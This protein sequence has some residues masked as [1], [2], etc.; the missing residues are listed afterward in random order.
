MLDTVHRRDKHVE[1]LIEHFNA[2]M[3]AANNDVN[4]LRASLTPA[5]KQLISDELARVSGPDPESM[6]YFLENYFVINTKGGQFD[7]EMAEQELRTMSPFMDP[8]EVLWEEVVY[9]WGHKLPMWWIMLKARQIGW[10]T[11]VQGMLFQRVIF[12]KNMSVLVIADE[13]TRT[14]NIFDKSLLAYNNLPFFM[15]PEIQLN[16]R[17]KGILRFDRN[18]QD[19]RLVNP[20]LN[21]TFFTD[22]AN[23][24][25]GSSRGFTLHGL[26]A[27]EFGLFLRPKILTQDIVP[28]LAKKNPLTIAVV[29]GT[30]DEGHN[31]TYKA[32]WEMAMKG[33]GLF[34]PMFAA[35]WK[36]KT[37]CK[38]FSSLTEEHG[39]LETQKTQHPEELELM[40]KVEDEFGYRIR[41]DQMNWY[42][43]QADQFEGTEADREM[44]EQEYPSYPKSAFRTGGICAFPRK[45]LT[46]IEVRDVR[47]PIWWGELLFRMEGDQ[48]KPYFIKHG[49]AKRDHNGD[50]MPGQQ[51]LP[52]YGAPLWI[53]E[54]PVSKDIYYEASD[55]SQGIPDAHERTDFAAAQIFRVPRKAGERIRQCLEFKGY[56]DPKTLAKIVCQLGKFYN[57]CEMAPE[58]NTLTEHIGNIIHI[59]KYPNIYRWRRQDKITGHWTNFF[60]WETQSKSRED[61]MARFKALLIEDSIEIRSQRLLDEAMNFVDDGS[62]R[63]EAVGG[64]HDDTLFAAMICV[65]CLMELDPRLFR[66]VDEVPMDKTNRNFHNTDYS[67]SDKEQEAMDTDFACL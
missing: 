60:G 40:S 18:D 20:G 36:E 35:W 52:L 9:C 43:E 47:T 65:Y 15:R 51:E 24:P 34:R 50:I 19:M 14:Q 33:K 59:H 57:M 56:V 17:G 23:K 27:S 66:L 3:V 5:E 29:E 38:P 30:A 44:M 2:R 61:L 55:P 25:S 6:R 46:R 39:F 31:K 42:R 11:I 64:Q 54:W 67:I 4:V 7:D 48:E 62:G 37:Y 53:W 28:A 16:N 26:H 10:S 45:K 41:P 32:M 13:L 1:Q 22:A 21:S 63:F 12:N 8:Q 49:P 58:C